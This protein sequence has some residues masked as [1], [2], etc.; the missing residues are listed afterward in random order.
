[1]GR[2]SRGQDTVDEEGN[3]VYGT[4]RLYAFMNG[5]VGFNPG[6]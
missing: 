1:M 2:G 4:E 6:N 3:S 5:W